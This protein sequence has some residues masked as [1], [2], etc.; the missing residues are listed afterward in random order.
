[1]TMLWA[2]VGVGIGS[3]VFRVVPLA[4]AGQLPERLSRVA[5]W[6]GLAVISALS[7]RAVL[8][9]EDPSIPGASLVAAVSVATGLLLAHRGSS[10]L[11]AVGVGGSTYLIIAAA[12]AALT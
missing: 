4:S 10:V 2:V 12:V 3:L 6:T 1:M 8:Q 5:G 11:V 9:V 7:V